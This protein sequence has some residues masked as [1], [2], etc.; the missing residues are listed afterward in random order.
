MTHLHHMRRR[1]GGRG[2]G[3]V[4]G[5][6]AALI[7]AA[8]LTG[9]AFLCRWVPDPW[10]PLVPVTLAEPITPLT[11]WK[12]Q[13]AAADSAL[14][15]ALLAEAGNAAIPDRAEGPACGIRAGVRLA[16]LSVAALDPVDTRCAVALRLWFWE[17]ELQ[18]EAVALLGSPV[19]RI[20]HLASYACRPM[21]TADGESLRM[22]SH[23]TASAIDIAGFRLADGR[24][25]SVRGDWPRG[26]AAGLF[27]RVANRL[28]CR[29]FTGV[30]GPGYDARHA[31]HFHLEAGRWR[32]CR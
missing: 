26:D 24:R 3:P 23:A 15:R 7:A 1:P 2:G 6:L 13:R 16:A 28:G 21:R 4:A 10:N 17:R 29:W 30:L 32:F 5:L 8:L 19:A 9:A 22:S 27:L 20:E 31:D 11:P 18:A 14:C 12:V 25:V